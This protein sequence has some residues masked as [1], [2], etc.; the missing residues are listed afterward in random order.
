MNK[1]IQKN[2]LLNNNRFPFFD[3]VK[4]EAYK[5]YKFIITNKWRRNVPVLLVIL[6]VICTEIYCFFGDDL[7]IYR[8]RYCC[9]SLII[10]C[11]TL[12]FIFSKNKELLRVIFF[13]SLLFSSIFIIHTALLYGNRGGF[14]IENLMHLSDIHSM[15]Q[16]FNLDP[17]L[18]WKFPLCILLL[19]IVISVSAFSFILACHP[20]PVKNIYTRVIWICIAGAAVYFFAI[21]FHPAKDLITIYK[22]AVE[23]N[24]YMTFD[25]KT[26]QE[27]GVKVTD[28]NPDDVTASPGKNLVF[29]IL[30][31][32][33][34]AYLDEKRFPGLLPNL[35]KYRKQCQSFENMQMAENATLTFGAMFSMMTGS[36]LTA[37]YLTHGVNSHTKTYIGSKL[38]SFPQI[39]NKAHYQQYFLVGHSENFAGTGNFVKKLK[40]NEAWFG[41][42]RSLRESSWEFSLRDSKVFEKAWQLFQAAAEQKKPFNIT[43]LT[44]DAHGPNGFYDPAEPPFPSGATGLRGQ[45]YNAMYASDHALGKFLKRIE[46]H[47]ASSNT[48]IVIVSDHLAHNYTVS[49]PLLAQKENR[50]LLFL[51]KNSVQKEYDQNIEAMTF[52]IAPTIL[53]AMGVKHDYIFPLGESLYSKPDPKRLLHSQEQSLAL[54]FYTI[55][56]STRLGKSIFGRFFLLLFVFCN[57]LIY[58]LN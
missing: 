40:Y 55:I 42:D 8:D 51:V 19:T 57:F 33:E 31:S 27:Y 17:N 3:T 45:L 6:A 15:L 18:L 35:Q 1:K 14:S 26:Y 47:P 49:T 29:I 52:D 20:K 53:E 38:S 24:N 37:E 48:C 56:K 21:T 2:E 25:K 12:F 5:F 50:R 16:I 36:F 7:T 41:I 39:L 9:Y 13:T 32:T 46:K 54:R 34:L 43:L 28:K 11:S 58:F 10:F 30:E 44:I 4:K 22:S 23:L